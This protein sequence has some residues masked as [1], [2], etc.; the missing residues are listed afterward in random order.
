VIGV[1]SPHS[2][3][4]GR[5]RLEKFNMTD[6]TAD[7][8]Q[9]LAELDRLRKR[10]A[11]LEERERLHGPIIDRIREEVLRMQRGEDIEPVLTAVWKG[12]EQLGIPFDRCGVNVIEVDIEPPIVHY[13]T[14]GAGGELKVESV[15]TA[16]N[17]GAAN[18]VDFWRSRRPAY[19]NDLRKENPFGETWM[20]Y[21]CVIDIPFSHGTLA[22]SGDEANAFSPEDI[23]FL[24][25]MAQVLSEGFR[26]MD[27]LRTL[28]RRHRA[29]EEGN[30][31][32]L[33][34][35]QIGR[36]ALLSL[37]REAIL[38]NLATQ[39]V[40][41]GIFR[42]LMISLVDE[43]RGV[44]WV[45]G[46][47]NLSEENQI[48]ELQDSTGWVISI[49]DPED[50]GALAIRQKKIYLKEGWG[51]PLRPEPQS[52]E[53]KLAVAYFLPVLGRGKQVR[54]LL[55]TASSPE[56][57]EA[58]L[59]RIEAMQ[60]LLDQVAI[61]L[62]H[63]QVHE[64]LRGSEERY[65]RLFE[66]SNDAILIHDVAGKMVDVNSR[67]CEMLGYGRDELTER[68]IASLHP[69]GE[70][71]TSRKA[72]QTIAERGAVR[73]ESK[74]QRAD[75]ELIDVDISSRLM[76]EDR[77][78]IQGI[79]RDITG[80]KRME[81]ELIHLERVHAIGELAAGVSHN[82][83]NI[84]TGV[85]GPAQILRRN[86]EEPRLLRET[87]DIIN[88]A[89]RARDL[90]QQLN[91]AVRQEQGEGALERV[92]IASSVQEAIQA[93]RPRWKDEAEARGRRIEV[94]AEG[95]E[96]VAISGTPT[97]L[98]D[99]LLNLLFNAVDAMPEGG[100][101][102]IQTRVTESHV[103]L[104]VADTGKGMDEKMQQRI[105]EPFFTTKMDVGTG[106]GLSTVRSTVGRWGGRVEVES[107]SGRGT[108]FTLYLPIWRDAASD[109]TASPPPAQ[110]RVLIVED[111]EGTGLLLKRFLEERYE[112]AVVGSGAEA[113]ER[114]AAG[115]WEVALIDLGM[116]GMPGDKAAKRLKE[117][118]P[119]LALV[120]ITGWELPD[121]DAR[122]EIFDFRLQ[123]PFEDLDEV[124][125]MITRA[126][127]LHDARG[128]QM[129]QTEG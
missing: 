46:S 121:E 127:E 84:L 104:I 88:S 109:A 126:V 65:R 69:T 128:R 28:E 2:I 3:F 17:R 77:G 83:N 72:L 119:Q 73:F 58:L 18:V 16:K 82:L 105:F 23:E 100:R 4:G 21:A 11:E 5:E 9:L 90:V 43:E 19:R 30:R 107:A 123:K 124:E 129:R 54:A 1:S 10:V 15:S 50:H 14:L 117:M 63:A 91:Q 44:F 24:Q 114:F 41:Q 34:F 59:Q 8:T 93:S 36:V 48:Q 35:Q 108:A 85:L 68:D 37:D 66:E 62:E 61:A 96:R 103:E 87:E 81:R 60:P 33:I 57:R 75:G 116:P 22:V 101:I 25:K 52:P 13:H 98:H 56:E 102:D 20:P 40:R 113:L 55:G 122:L 78:I 27:D 115:E 76:G 80:R 120:L 64:D 112:A 67:A 89:R 111:D 95:V 7:K 94:M 32:L 86:L 118:D 42:S 79:V 45:I 70:L 106:L 71:E 12:L 31:W 6:G 39:V 47:Y 97:G 110:G 49:Q 38:K 99:I 51:H 125:K 74:F 53:E 26:R 92:N 29:L